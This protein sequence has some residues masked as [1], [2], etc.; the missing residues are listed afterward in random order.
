[1]SSD[2]PG[3]KQ[4]RGLQRDYLATEKI[5]WPP[6]TQSQSETFKAWWRDTLLRGGAWFTASWPSPQGGTLHRRFL[7]PPQ[8]QYIH[9]GTDKRM[10]RVSAE[11]EVRGRGV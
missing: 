4:F 11:C 5:T 3:P 10:W 8:W 2:I 1:M 9:A 7:A 6:F